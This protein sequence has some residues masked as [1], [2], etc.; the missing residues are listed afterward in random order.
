MNA[1]LDLVL[2]P[3]KV[4]LDWLIGEL[5]RLRSDRNG[6]WIKSRELGIA[7]TEAQKRRIREIKQMSKG[8]VVAWPGSPGYKLLNDCTLEELR[9]GDR[10]MRSQ[11]RAMAAE[12]AAYLAAHARP[13]ACRCLESAV[14]GQRPARRS[15]DSGHPGA[16]IFAHEDRFSRSVPDD[17]RKYVDPDEPRRR[18][19]SP[20]RSRE[21]GSLQTSLPLDDGPDRS[22]GLYRRGDSILVLSCRPGVLRAEIGARFVTPNRALPGSRGG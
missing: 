6:G 21:V 20:D 12:V 14:S 17:D 4:D 2:P 3:S 8:A 10:A 13:G 15:R 19:P 16:S 5:K 7:L 9:H 22:A 11:L 18:V 1:Q